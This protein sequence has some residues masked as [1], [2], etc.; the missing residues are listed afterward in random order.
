MFFYQPVKHICFFYPKILTSRNSRDYKDVD[1][2]LN[3]IFVG[4]NVDK[5]I[6]IG[7]I[8][9]HQSNHFFVHVRINAC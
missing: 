1:A 6:S 4:A 8:E 3:E 9:V 2:L 7:R 5:K